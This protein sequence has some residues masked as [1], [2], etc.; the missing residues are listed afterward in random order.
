MHGKG[1]VGCAKG[2]AAMKRV[3]GLALFPLAFV[4]AVVVVALS[5]ACLALADLPGDDPEWE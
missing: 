3:V 2:G 5:A 1:E 4:Q